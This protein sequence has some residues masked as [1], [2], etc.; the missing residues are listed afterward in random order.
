MSEEFEKKLKQKIITLKAKQ[1]SQSQLEDKNKMLEITLT[2]NKKALKKLKSEI[3]ELLH[4][5]ER[6]EMT[7]NDM[8]LKQKHKEEE[9]VQLRIEIERRIR[10]EIEIKRKVEEEISKMKKTSYEEEEEEREEENDDEVSKNSDRSS[11]CDLCEKQLCD[12]TSLKKHLLSKQHLKIVE[13]MEKKSKE[14]NKKRKAIPK[15]VRTTLWNIHFSEDKA[16]GNCKVCDGEI[17]ISNFEAGHVIA[18]ACGG[19]DNLDNLLPLCSLCNKSMGTENLLD[20][21]TKYFSKTT[22]SKTD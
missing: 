15:A 17:K 12:T 13:E 4:D 9:D 11:Y 1:T 10:E 7:L 18:S 2:D 16:K 6:S 14:L 21:K 8:K 3:D 19:S 5:V 22:K 20:F